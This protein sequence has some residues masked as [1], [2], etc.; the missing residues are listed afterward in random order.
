MP[1]RR[2]GWAAGTWKSDHPEIQCVAAAGQLSVLAEPR[3][4]PSSLPLT[5]TCSQRWR[6]V[7]VRIDPGS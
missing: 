4:W 1:V 3:R 7:T 5:V 2:A 6:T